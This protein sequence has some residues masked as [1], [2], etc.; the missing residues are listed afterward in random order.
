ML[1]EEAANPSDRRALSVQIVRGRITQ[2][3][4]ALQAKVDSQI[5]T[6]TTTTLACDSDGR[7]QLVT[8]SGRALSR[9]RERPETCKTSPFLFC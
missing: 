7:G 6:I 2:E 3:E 1:E 9:A 8:A 5:V 4:E